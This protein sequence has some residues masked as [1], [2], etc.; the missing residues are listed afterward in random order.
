MH[1]LIWIVSGMLAGAGVGVVMRDRSYG[2]AGSLLIGTAGGIVGGWLIHHG[3]GLTAP[4]SFGWHLLSSLVGGTLFVTAVRTLDRAAGAVVPG[5]A[6][7]PVDDALHRLGALEHR[8][9]ADLLQRRPVARDTNAELAEHTTFGQR[10]ADRVAAFGGSWPF[11]GI[12]LA[13]MVTWMFLNSRAAR[14]FDPFPFIL[15]NL[16]LSCVA[17]L[18]AP[19]I[20]MSQNRQATRDRLE[21]RNDYQVNVHAEMQVGALHAKFDELRARE[22]D[23]LMEIQRRQ[24]V[25]LE[26]LGQVPGP[27]HGDSE[28]AGEQ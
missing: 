1:I 6:D 25:I 15:L 7:R 11:I 26:A 17:A 27:S 28:A 21:A 23:G 8:L 3:L 4:T 22:W 9:W 14:P 18:Q 20:M 13:L 10:V 12:F 16:V 19:V 2:L 5:V 24:L